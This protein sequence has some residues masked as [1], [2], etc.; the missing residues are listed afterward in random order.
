MIGLRG[1]ELMDPDGHVL[2]FGR[3][4]ACISANGCRRGIRQG[5][6][7]LTW[8]SWCASAHC[9]LSDDSKSCA[10][11]FQHLCLPRHVADGFASADVAAKEKFVPPSGCKKHGCEIAELEA[12]LKGERKVPF[13]RKAKNVKFCNLL[14]PQVSQAVKRAGQ[15][16]V[17]II[18]FDVTG[19]GRVVGQQLIAG[20]GTPG[21]KLCSSML[22]T[23]YSSPLWRTVLELPVSV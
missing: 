16:G 10:A 15:S 14:Q 5:R 17:A 8:R 19:S 9:R 7:S 20:K 4:V 22:R 1:F 11:R 13:D 21:V 12:S 3:P 18:V 6:I 23:G 2:F